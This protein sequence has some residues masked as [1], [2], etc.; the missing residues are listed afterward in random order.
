M[1]E[2]LIMVVSVVFMASPVLAL[3]VA[4]VL[5]EIDREKNKSEETDGEDGKE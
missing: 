3:I 4:G 1:K 2:A 5:W